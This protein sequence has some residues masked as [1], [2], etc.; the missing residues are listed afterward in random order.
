MREDQRANLDNKKK[1]LHQKLL[2]EEE[3]KQLQLAYLPFLD[4]L[5]KPLRFEYF[6]CVNEE[7][8]SLWFNAIDNPP[9]SAYSIP[10]D[11]IKV[12]DQ[13]L[14]QKMMDVFPGYLPL[15][16][17]PCLPFHIHQQQ[18]LAK[19]LPGA[20]KSLGIIENEDV[21]LLFTR[22]QPV[23]RLSL[24]DILQI[25]N[26]DFPWSEDLCIM[27][28]KLEW[29]IFRSL[30]DEWRWGTTAMGKHH[31]NPGDNI[32]LI[33]TGIQSIPELRKMLKIFDQKY[34]ID[35]DDN[36]FI[37]K[38]GLFIQSKAEDLLVVWKGK[39]VWL[40]VILNKEN[41]KWKIYTSK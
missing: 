7:N 1:A 31:F 3:I 21:Y 16:Y 15:R 10:A 6:Q 34:G 13:S 26:D 12:C 36:A 29:L 18:N 5:S 9:L 40:D 41:G 19:V 23:L 37:L 35:Y 4:K 33:E 22:Y 30:E 25:D 39:D 38:H 17:M 14:H 24:A 8:K 2:V 11:A 28:K 20:M 32:R 27:S